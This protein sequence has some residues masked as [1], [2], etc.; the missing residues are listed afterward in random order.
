MI[1]DCGTKLGPYEILAPLGA[2]GMGE[3]YKGRDTRLDRIVAIKISQEKFSE[4]FEREARAV[5]ALNHPNICTLYDVGP[6]YLV[7]EFV[8]GAP[9]KGPLPVEKAVEYARQIL[10]A[11]DAAHRKGITHRDLKPAN[12]L[13]AKQGIKLLDFG[14]AKQSGPLHEIDATLTAALTGKGQILGTLQYISPEQLQGKEAD[15]RSDLFAF[16]CV[17]YEMLT[18]KRA[19]Q[20][21]SAAS[22]IA[23]ILER[24]PAPLSASPPLDRIVRRCLAKDPDQR[25]QNALDLKTA[26]L[27]ALERPVAAIV[28][29]RAWISAAA[30]TL[31]LGAVGGGWTVSHFREPPADDQV[32]RF[33]IS[34]PEGGGISGGGNLGG[35]FAISPDGRTAAFVGVVKGK[36][37]LWVRPLDAA[38]ARL[39]RGS[40]G[41]SRPFWSPDSR[42]IAF[43]ARGVLQRVD[44]LGETISKI[45]DVAGSLTGGS[46][47]SDGRILFGLLSTGIFQVPAAG[48]A[49]SQVT[50]ADRAHGEVSHI[51]PQALPG[52]RLLYRV[53]SA[54]PQ[55]AGVYATSFAKPAERVRLLA[56]AS[57]AWYSSG[58]GDE[59]HLLWIR[60]RTLLAQRFNADKLQLIGEPHPLAEPAVMATSAKRVLLYGSS[61]ALRQ[62][63]WLDS[64]GNEV[65][66][67]GEPGPWVFSRF[68][69]DAKRVVT[70]ASGD[71]ADIWLIETSRGVPSRLTSGRGA[72]ISPVWSPD[73]RTIMYSSG[74]PFNL[75]RIASDGAG[76]EERVTQSPNAQTAND[77][78]H[79]GRFI[80]YAEAAPDTG[81]DLWVLPVTPEGRPSPGAKAWPF[82]RERFDQTMARFSPDTRWVAY[83]SDESGQSEVYVRSFPEPR[84][85]LRI[86]TSGGVYPQWG[87]DGR[88]VF[89]QSRDGRLMIVTLK[90][91]GASWEASLPRE[92]FAF[93]AFGGGSPYEATPDGQRFLTGGTSASPEPLTVIV[94]WP[95]L[96]KKGAATQ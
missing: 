33:Q 46:W 76:V 42:S 50:I 14:L 85:K 18:G 82:V 8:E 64:R 21:Q 32:I 56:D 77:W 28:S 5:S 12:I 23:A 52:G 84:E 3:V 61:A 38:N 65:G 80:I 30:I 20:G 19:F 93:Q 7:M 54:D 35:G 40:E 9:L 34:P 75:F 70:I 22:V 15:A 44:L 79:N 26:L 90:L 71:P 72:R 49:P 55:N 96:L 73:G 91:V 2:G 4:R 62:F 60:D 51:G 86:S 89:Y 45:C 39:I 41:A 59:D 37:G 88:E 11:L 1:L 29:R 63:K 74:A 57:D 94:N 81:R 58:G 31:L 10:D 25:F 43:S 6:N 87:S 78:S 95:A 83:Q 13:L 67:L 24:E 27:W 48:G 92:L 36:T 16:G 47:S 68:S 66:L 17:L 53:Y 69:P